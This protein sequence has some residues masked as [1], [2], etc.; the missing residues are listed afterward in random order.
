[1]SYEEK[2]SV[3][4]GIIKSYTA[5]D[6]AIAF[7]GGTDSSLLLSLAAEHARKN[8]T[9]ALAVTICTE[10]HTMNDLAVSEQV[11][12]EMGVELV[13]LKVDELTQAGIANNPLN[14]CYLCKKLLFTKAKELADKRG[15]SI[16]MDGTNADDLTVYRPGLQ[17]LKEI[18]IKSPLME[19]G[20]SKEEVRMLAEEYG[21]SVADRPS[22]PCL[23]TRFPYGDRI[24]IEKLHRVD[25]GE[26]YL[27]T[28]G[29][30]NVRIRVH[31]NIARIEVD[32]K[33]MGKLILNRDLI[34]KHLKALGYTYITLDLEGFR[35]GSMDVDVVKQR[36]TGD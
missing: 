4:H 22:A 18:G 3:L 2:C 16:I 8:H 15:I 11:A 36:Q 13:V 28:L 30:Y 33:Y 19:A 29:L 24:T 6:T 27:R 31:G 1:M 23:A 34:T 17:A 26:N 32:S 21:I 25:E 20:F 10:L 35:S 7:S 14:R 12:R 9:T 5:E